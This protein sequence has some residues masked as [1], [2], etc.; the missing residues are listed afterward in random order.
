MARCD[1]D[2]WH[3][4]GRE[5]NQPE[6][7]EIGRVIP[8]PSAGFYDFDDYERLVAAAKANDRNAYLVV[9]LDGEAGLRW[10]GSWR[11]NGATWI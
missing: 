3:T 4:V 11:S 8:K 2:R 5:R 10:R 1:A 6:A 7:G 9:L